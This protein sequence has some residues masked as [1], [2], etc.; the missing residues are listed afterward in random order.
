MEDEQ[1]VQALKN[2]L[3]NKTAVQSFLSRVQ[4]RQSIDPR[5]LHRIKFD[6]GHFYEARTLETEEGLADIL[7]QYLTKPKDLR[8][9]RKEWNAFKNKYK[10]YIKLS[11][12]QEKAMLEMIVKPFYLVLGSAGAVVK[13]ITEYS[14][15]GKT[16]LEAIFVLFLEHIGTHVYLA[17]MVGKAA[18]RA[19]DVL[20]ERIKQL[21]SGS[22]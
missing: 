3:P 17:T 22:L 19:A 7:S 18:V 16:T 14:G 1:V 13:N 4:N 9:V 6:K 20:L 10:Q 12:E 21:N 2:D 5:C 15:T 8:N 11:L